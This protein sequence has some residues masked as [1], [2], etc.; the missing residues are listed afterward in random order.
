MEKKYRLIDNKMIIDLKTPKQE[1]LLINLLYGL[2]DLLSKQEV[3]ILCKWNQHGIAFPLSQAE[4]IFYNSLKE[5]FYILPKEREMELKSK[6]IDSLSLSPIEKLTHSK[7]ASFIFS[8]QCNFKCP[9]C[10]ENNRKNNSNVMTRDMIDKVI[11]LYKNGINHIGLFGGEPLLPQNEELVNYIIQK[12]PNAYYTIITNG[13]FLDYYIPILKKIK[14]GMIQITLEGTKDNHNKTRILHD[15]SP[16]YDKILSNIKK[17]I[18]NKFP[19]KIR[20]NLSKSNFDDCYKARNEL[21]SILGEKNV[22]FEMQPLFN[23]SYKDQ[24]KFLESMLLCDNYCNKKNVIWHTLPPLSNFVF[25]RKPLRPLIKFCESENENRFFDC[26][27]NI[28]SCILSVG[29]TNKRVGTFYPQ[30][31]LHEKSLLTYD[32]TQNMVCKKC[33]YALICGGGCPYH[34]MNEEGKIINCNCSNIKNEIENIIPMLYNKFS[35]SL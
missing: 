30:F 13:Y 23:Y 15:G 1:Y 33:N 29:E 6:I 28:Y 31:Q 11:L 24:S 7:S 8:Y 27:G 32:I 26:D 17:C 5:R 20:M 18:K 2:V 16:T 3:D 9:Y 34:V 19:I 4:M 10:Y 12:V 25:N 14:V 21:M 22:D 35:R